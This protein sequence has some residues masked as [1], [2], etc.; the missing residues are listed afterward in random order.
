MRLLGKIKFNV[1]QHLSLFLSFFYLFY[2][3]LFLLLLLVFYV[4]S[5]VNFPRKNKQEPLSSYVFITI[6]ISDHE[7]QHHEV[8]VNSCVSQ[9]SKSTES[10]LHRMKHLFLHQT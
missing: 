10:F 1:D 4:H 7:K 8:D 5:A 6:N 3:C 9:S 2:W